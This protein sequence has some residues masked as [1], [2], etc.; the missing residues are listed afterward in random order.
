MS[1]QTSGKKVDIR[2]NGQGGSA[3]RPAASKPG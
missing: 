1:Q 2:A 3:A